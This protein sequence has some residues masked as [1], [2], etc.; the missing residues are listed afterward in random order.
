SAHAFLPE[1]PADLTARFAR[2]PAQAAPARRPPPRHLAALLS[3]RYTRVVA[4]DNTVRLG[5][6]WLQLPRQRSYAGRRLELRECFD[7]RLLAFADDAC[8]ATQPP[9]PAFVLRPRHQPSA[10]R[11]RRRR[12][13]P[14]QIGRA[15]V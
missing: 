12:A 5:P 15:H 14:S 10:D 1:F 11:A 3:C 8:L 13:S 9:P 2:A 4:H 7:G 6:R